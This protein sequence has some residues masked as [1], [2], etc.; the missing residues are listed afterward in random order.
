VTNEDAGDIV[1]ESVRNLAGQDIH[2]RA[3]L[4]I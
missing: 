1:P 2:A 4:D 3:R